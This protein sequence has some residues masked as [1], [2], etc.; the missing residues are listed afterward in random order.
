MPGPDEPLLPP[1]PIDE[2]PPTVELVGFGPSAN[3]IGATEPNPEDIAAMKRRRIMRILVA[4]AVVAVGAL[5]IF[6]GPGI[7]RGIK[8]WRATVLAKQA[9]DE[10]AH[11]HLDDAV[12]TIR[13]AFMMSPSEPAVLRS[14]AKILSTIN[15][16][17]AMMY[18]N[19]V[20]DSNQCTDDDRRAAAE[21]AMRQKMLS[22]AIAIV[23]DLMRRD[24]QNAQNLLMTARLYSQSGDAGQAMVYATRAALTDPNNKPAAIFLAQ[25]ELKNPHLRQ[26]GIEGML[27]IADTDD[28]YG[29]LALQYVAGLP[30]LSRAELDHVIERLHA[31]PLG[32]E[33][34]K[35]SALA[36]EIKRDP[37]QRKALLDE[38]VKTRQGLP[39]EKLEEFAIWL[40]AMGEP[41]RVLDVVP[42]ERALETNKLFMA[43]MDALSSLKKWDTLRPILLHDKV[44]L[45]PAMTQLYL[46]RASQELDD[47][48]SADLYWR[49]AQAAAAHN[50]KQSIFIA[51]YAERMGE[52]DRA[53]KIYLMLTQEP[54]VARVA[55][56]GLLR[57]DDGKDT[58]KTRDI[59]DQMVVR[60]PQEPA[61]LNDDIYFNLL[62]NARVQEMAQKAYELVQYDPGSLPHRTALALAFLRLKQPGNA[63]KVYRTAKTDWDKAPI[64]ALVVYAAT[65]EANGQHNEARHRAIL[66]PR[67]QL[68]PEE[69]ALIKSLLP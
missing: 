42:K 66:L 9:E 31:H 11:Q 4:L 69:A 53:R 1:E 8:S 61:V 40:N 27:K 24:P 39:A 14:M 20:L 48:V 62:L 68:R 29:L 57:L 7:Y 58:E 21:C 44:P 67:D 22:R 37:T 17:G 34:Q 60:W 6:I 12:E 33:T 50:S 47:T 2:P 25:Q 15:V 54:I 30:D 55:F 41:A 56:M 46:A 65:L 51:L 45:E 43:Y 64:S 59:L 26:T 3:L 63:L 49:G 38:A 10:L 13:S 19:W 36:L 16:P 18:W 35:V 5:I 32:Q 52:K 28:I 23:G